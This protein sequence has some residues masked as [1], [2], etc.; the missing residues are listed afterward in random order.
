[1]FKIFKTTDF[2]KIKYLFNDIRFFMGNSVLDGVMGEAYVDNLDHPEFAILIV[3]NYCFI[4]GKIE[5]KELKKLIEDKLS[6]YNIV[7]SDYLKIIIEDTFGQN[8]FKGERYSI[9]KNPNF[10][11]TELKKYIS[12]IN[13]KFQIKKIDYDM[14]NRIKKEKFINITDDYQKH[15]VGYCCVYNNEIIGVASSNIFYK[16]GIE[17]NIKVKEEYRKLGI[18]TALAS[19][20][21]LECLHEKRKISWDAAHIGSVKLAEKLGFKFHSK[22]NFYILNKKSVIAENDIEAIIKKSNVRGLSIATINDFEI[23]YYGV[24]G[25]CESEKKQ[26]IEKDTLFQVASISKTVFATAIMNMYQHGIIDIDCDID[27]YLVNWQLDGKLNTK[28]TLR[29]LLS[30]NGGINVGGFRGYTKNEVLP[31]TLEIL[32]GHGNSEKICRVTNEYQY[33]GGG[34]TILQYIVENIFKK[35]SFQEILNKYL[36]NL[37]D[38]KYSKYFLSLCDSDKI[39]SDNYNTYPEYAAA[40]LYSTAYD[41]AKLGLNIQKSLLGHGFINKKI[42][43]SMLT[44]VNNKDHGIGFRIS[45]DGNNFWHGGINNN[46]KSYMFFTKDGKGIIILTNDSKEKIFDELSSYIKQKYNWYNVNINSFDKITI[47]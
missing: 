12:K 27:K 36:F 30:H 7:P 17:V 14:S 35:Y 2:K 47:L 32:N 29:D 13:K 25:N 39:A 10:K 1:M 4:S 8:I 46:Y 24:F 41:I 43:N 22:Y 9:N 19:S 6:D 23:D 26:Q 16:D 40:G 45:S 31:T 20:L 34:Y 5:K 11:T 42:A 33:S 44:R 21:I 37:I 18:A 38:M 28:I 3:R 15:G